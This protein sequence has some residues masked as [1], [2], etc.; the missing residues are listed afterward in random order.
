VQNCAKAARYCESLRNRLAA[1]RLSKSLH[2]QRIAIS[3]RLQ[4][5]LPDFWAAWTSRC[6]NIASELWKKAYFKASALGVFMEFQEKAAGKDQFLTAII[7][8]WNNLT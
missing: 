8:V 4:P 6:P 5:Y 2:W 1:W 7:T 3:R